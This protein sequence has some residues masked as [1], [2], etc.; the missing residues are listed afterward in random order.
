M[1]EMPH[2][3]RQVW[4]RRPGIVLFVA[5]LG[6]RLAFVMAAGINAPPTP[7]GDDPHYDQIATE[8]VTHHRY[9]NTWFPPGYPLFLAL[10]YAL[11]GRQLAVV[12]LLQALCG[13]LTC[14]L[15]FRLGAKLFDERDGRLAGMLLVFYPGHAYMS[16]RLMG[17]SV[18][19]LLLVL[20]LN[21]AVESARQPRLRVAVGL[22]CTVGL[23]Q[24]VKSNLFVFPPLLVAWAA[25]ALPGSLR[26][27]LVPLCGLVASLALVSLATPIANLVSTGGGA[28]T[29]PGNAGRTFW[30]ANNPLADGYYITAEQEPAGKAFIAAHGFTARLAGADEFEKDRLYRRLALLWIR[31]NPGR[32][33]VLCL[34]KIDNAF[35]LFP[36]AVTFE[37]NPTARAVHLLSYGL[38]APFALAG[39]LAS[40]RRWRSHALLHTVLASYVIMVLIFYGTPR[41]T[42]IVMPVLLIFASYA[43][44]SSFDYLRAT[45]LLSGGVTAGG[46]RHVIRKPDLRAPVRRSRP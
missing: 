40:W 17:E 13:A 41:F 32:F 39:L 12:R 16:W 19:I 26:Q 37:G 42:I 20:A 38:L 29:L 36:R 3:L 21:L 27:R 43:L 33:F 2:S 35:G 22:G 1:S 31:E 10:I 15:T 23:A 28:A 45:A 14:L 11:A 8:L 34:K 5:A 6:V 9:V 25:W 7:W 24:L 4:Q 30:Y 44:V 46:P 18:F